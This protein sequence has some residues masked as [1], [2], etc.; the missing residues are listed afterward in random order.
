MSFPVNFR[1]TVPHFFET[2][3]GFTTTGASVLG[4]VESLSQE[5]LLWRALTQWLGGLGV[6]VLFIAILSQ[7]DTG[8]V[9]MFRAESSGPTTERLASHI[10]IRRL[11]FGSPM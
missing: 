3:S 2:M 8:G 5:L 11:F 10:K 9:T 7:L 6:V 4:D 1:I